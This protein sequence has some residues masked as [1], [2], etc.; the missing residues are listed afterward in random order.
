M[1]AQA[2]ILV[3]IIKSALR[4]RVVE[5]PLAGKVSIA[6]TAPLASSSM[7]KTSDKIIALGASTGGPGALRQRMVIL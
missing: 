1:E 7:F 3:G 6:K 5:K 4:A 2:E